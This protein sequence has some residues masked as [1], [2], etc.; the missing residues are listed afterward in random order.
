MDINSIGGNYSDIVR[1]IE[2][3]KESQIQAMYAVKL[4]K[5]AQE[6]DAVTADLLE[7]VVEISKEAMEKFLSERV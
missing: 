4:L 3:E 2:A 1:M 6:S 5:M 7:D